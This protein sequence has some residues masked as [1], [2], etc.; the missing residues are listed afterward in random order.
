MS[1]ATTSN[2]NSSY[3]F[4]TDFPGIGT[5]TADKLT[6]DH[7]IESGEDLARTYLT[8]DARRLYD[9]I[10]EQQRARFHYA[11]LDS[12]LTD[13]DLGV[14][15]D[16]HGLEAMVFIRAFGLSRNFDDEATLSPRHKARIRPTE[17]DFSKGGLMCANNIVAYVWDT[18]TF[19]E[20]ADFK[21][22]P[23]EITQPVQKFDTD[24]KTRIVVS[25]ETE[26]NS[27]FLTTNQLS[28]AEHLFG[29]DVFDEPSR[30]RTHPDEM[31]PVFIDNYAEDRL[32]IIAPRTE[33][34]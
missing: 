15:A 26:T 6:L 31:Y 18:E 33:G 23:A 8:T 7:G 1:N 17:V 11:L 2:F 30:M 22:W 12:G 29:F 27:T 19:Y 5:V 13:D 32:L 20:Y 4:T 34:K 24:Y 16:G 21:D 14:D 10:Q 28:V 3:N 9:D 25:A